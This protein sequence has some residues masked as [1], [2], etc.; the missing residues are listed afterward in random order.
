MFRVNTTLASVVDQSGLSAFIIMR[1]AMAQ[2]PLVAAWLVTPL[3]P[4]FM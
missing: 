1:T 3:K 2:Q 4:I